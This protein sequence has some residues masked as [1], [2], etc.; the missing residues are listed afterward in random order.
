[1]NDLKHVI[2][3][4]PLVKRIKELEHYIDSNSQLNEMIQQLK[5]LQKQ[6]VHA[7]EFHQPHQ[8]SVYKKQYDELNSQILDF[9]FV[10]EYIEL[11]EEA[12]NLI[13]DVAITIENKIN[14]KIRN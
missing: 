4:S 7:K 11:L 14:D 9:P 8:Y 3:S 13:K 2:V 1:M 6:M 10:E 12:N 5:E